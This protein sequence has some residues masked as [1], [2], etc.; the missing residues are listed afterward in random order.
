MDGAAQIHLRLRI[1]LLLDGVGMGAHGSFSWLGPDHR[2]RSV[3][4]Y[5]VGSYP[6]TRCKL[7][8]TDDSSATSCV[9]AATVFAL[10]ISAFR[11]GKGAARPDCAAK[12]RRHCVAS[13]RRGSPGS[14]RDARSR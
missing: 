4:G 1:E 5:K 10:K 13:A 9:P 7:L 8:A 6:I 11:A 12:K 14:S 2:A 3:S